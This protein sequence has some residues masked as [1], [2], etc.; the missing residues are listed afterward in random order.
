MSNSYRDNRG[1]VCKRRRRSGSPAWTKGTANQIP[2]SLCERCRGCCF[3]GSSN[4]EH[5]TVLNRQRRAQ[6]NTA[7]ING[8]DIPVFKTPWLD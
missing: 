3:K 4:K 1:N 2:Q 7:L 5:R 6:A 8:R